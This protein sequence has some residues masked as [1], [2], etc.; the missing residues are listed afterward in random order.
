MHPEENST[1]ANVCISQLQLSTISLSCRHQAGFEGGYKAD[2]QAEYHAGFRVGSDKVFKCQQALQWTLY[3][4][5]SH[6]GNPG[7]HPSLATTL[8]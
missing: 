7:I 8:I 4:Y 5:N 3:C 2:L 6:V 1:A